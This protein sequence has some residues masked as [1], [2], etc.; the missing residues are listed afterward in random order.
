MLI[1]TF[2]F[3]FFPETHMHFH[4]SGQIVERTKPC[5]D[6]HF[7]YT[8]TLGTMQVFYLITS[9]SKILTGSNSST[10]KIFAQFARSK[11]RS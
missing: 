5:T 6:P 11:R 2:S 3:F 7:V 10:V 4:G 1:Q 8:R 9:R